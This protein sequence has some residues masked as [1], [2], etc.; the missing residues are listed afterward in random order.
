MVEIVEVP[1]LIAAINPELYLATSSDP[2]KRK[3][4]IA[5]V[6]KKAKEEGVYYAAK[7]IK[8]TQCIKYS[9]KGS[10]DINFGIDPVG[11]IESK[12]QITYNSPTETL[13]PLYFWLLDLM[14]DTFG[15]S[16]EKI[17]DSFSSTP[18]SGH[19]SELNQKKSIMQQQVSQNMA[20]INNILRGILNIVYDLKDFKMRLQ[21]YKDLKSKDEHKSQSALL[22]LKQVWMD[23]V[24]MQKQGSSLKILASQGGFGNTLVES[25]LVAK[26]E[27]DVEKL[28]VNDRFKRLVKPR[29]N[30]FNIWLEHSEKELSKRYEIERNYLRSQVNSLKLSSRWAKPYLKA[31]TQLEQREQGRNPNLVTGF[32]TVLFQLTLLAKGEISPGD[33]AGSG[34][35]TTDLDKLKPKIKKKFYRCI[36]VDFEFLSLPNR[37]Q[38]GGYAFGGKIKI[39]WRAYALTDEELKA[40]DKALDKSDLGD[41]MSLIEGSTDE[42]L[43]KLQK[44]IDYFLEGKEPEEEKKEKEK[45]KEEEGS[46]PFLA[47]IGHY[48]KTE[49]PEKKQEISKDT[50]DKFSLTPDNWSEKLMRVGTAFEADDTTL[51]LYD[52]YKKAHGMLSFT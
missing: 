52:I 47:L 3:K 43:S 18:G 38:Q 11:G 39:N 20:T 36:L 41:M 31:A 14:T 21:H 37:L 46:N 50:G 29:I 25:F 6:K 10:D 40:L 7:K 42:S 35:L 4:E 34:M 32:N 27:E 22:A 23:K 12:Y 45:K 24:D 5:E 48:N 15:L 9:K 8:K 28:D 30:E 1:N 13:E 51:T 49:K 26:N 33:V 17:V 44:E 19:F 16:V 2:D